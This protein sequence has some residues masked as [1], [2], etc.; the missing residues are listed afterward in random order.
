VWHY[1]VVPAENWDYT[2]TMPIMLAD[3]KIDGRKRK[4]L[5]QAPKNGFFYVIDRTNGKL[6]SA[7][8]FAPNTWASHID[9]ASGRP[10]LLPNA[11]YDD[12]PKL[13]TP[14][15]IAA[16]SWYPMAY[17]PMTGLVYFPS[18]YAASVYEIEPDYKP[19]KWK[20]SWG[21]AAPPSEKNAAL[22]AELAKMERDGWLTAWDPVKQKEAWRVSYGKVNNGGVLA[23][24]GNLVVHGTSDQTV[25]AYRATDG[26]KLWEA[27]AQT[28]PMAGPITYTVDGEQYIAV[29][30]GGAATLP[31]VRNVPVGRA[32]AR[33]L[34][35]KLG[36]TAQLPPI[37][38]PPA[39]SAPPRLTAGEAQIKAGEAAYLK[40]CAQCHG[41][42]VVS[43][44]TIPD[45][46]NMTPETHAQF[47]DIV[48]R[49]TRASKGMVSFADLLTAQDSDAIHAYVIAR[50][51][52]D[53][54]K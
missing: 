2:A 28:V 27:P 39:R 18:L 46:R 14:N 37:P 33:M 4:V 5:M 24:A 32:A 17:S 23:T 15:G 31:A 53:W 47:D 51:W 22:R 34:A 38:P 9:L 54:N 12:G 3:L 40:T 10:V 41:E 52:D 44:N 8:K 7:E 20:M 25:A 45:L 19:E 1:Q 48:L 43:N 42:N 11:N 35:F 49:G 6:I 13:I 21:T 16:H 29:N 50:A 36:G 26:K 30:A